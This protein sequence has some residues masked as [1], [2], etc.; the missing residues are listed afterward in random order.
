VREK[1][2]NLLAVPDVIAAGDHFHSRRENLLGE[3]RRYAKAGGGIL[4]VRDAEIDRPLREDV[5]KPVVDDLAARRSHN[6]SDKEDFHTDLSGAETLNTEYTENGGVHR[7][8]MMETRRGPL[9]R[10]L[11]GPEPHE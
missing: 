1:I 5:G 8:K 10:A 2:E 4:S 11:L 7:E 6:V 9:R 3:P